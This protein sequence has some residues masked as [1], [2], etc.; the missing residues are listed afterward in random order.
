MK[1]SRGLKLVLVSAMVFLMVGMG[2]TAP[3]S[4]VAA[5]KETIKLRIGSGHPKTTDWVRF[6]SDFYCKEV[7][8]R[9]GE[10]TK[11]TL[12][13]SE[14]WAGSVAKLGEEL[15]S[16]EI[17]ILDMGALITPFEP[18]KMYIHN[19]AYNV[20]FYVSDPRAAARVHVK[21][22][23]EF[24]AFKNELRKYNQIYLGAGAVGD[25]GLNT[26]FPLRKT[27]DALNH[28][29]AAAG[30][31]LPFISG[32]GAVPVQ[33]NLNEAYSGLQT[34]V[35]EGWIMMPG[36]I[37]GFKL[38]EIAKH[39]TEMNFGAVNGVL[40]LT[41]NSKVWDKLPQEVRAIL[42]EVG[43]EYTV[44][45]ADYIV[46]VTKQAMKVL[47][48]NGTNI[49]IMPSEEKVKWAKK[50]INLPKKFAKEADAKGLPGTAIM[51][52]VMKYSEE[53]GHVFP[54]KWMD[55]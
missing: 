10:R 35:Y 42:Q 24:P 43:D 16:V 11:Y 48:D 29:I 45:E 23:K 47:K 17:G 7:V 31:N 55:E 44:K 9:V 32:V 12:E 51:R 37:V 1:K 15:E 38:Y 19:F 3:P 41:I 49:Y 52:A 14:H 8:K 2:I 28:K 36:S 54:R 53:E 21:L 46:D 34:G 50:L 22:F 13:L 4:V 25:Y 30:P 39:Y 18:T 33:G 27:G 20:P 26:T 40:V 5:A 6:L